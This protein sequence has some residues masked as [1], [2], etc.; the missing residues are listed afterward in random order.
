MSHR[1]TVGILA[2]CAAIATLWVAGSASADE[3]PFHPPIPILDSDGGKVAATGEPASPAQTC[4]ACHDTAFITAHA[5]HAHV[6]DLA[7]GTPGLQ[8]WDLGPGWFGAWDPI[9]GD[10][11]LA[12]ADDPV[13]IA[14]WMTTLGTRHAGGGPATGT[15]FD[16]LICHLEGVDLEARNAMIEAGRF[17][18][19]STAALAST[20]AVGYSAGVWSWIPEAFEPD[21]S[22]RG[23]EPQSPSATACSACH[24]V[25]VTEPEVV[26]VRALDDLNDRMTLLT[27][28]LI[29]GDRMVESGVNL[30]GK[31]D[32]SRPWDVHAERVVE[33][34]N[35]HH[36]VNNPA[37]FREGDATRPDH[38]L[39]DGRR[40]DPGLYLERPDHRLVNETCVTCHDATAAHEWLPYQDRHFEALACETC[41]IP[42][43]YAPALAVVDHTVVGTDGEPRREWRGV[44]GD[45]ASTATL[46]T[47]YEPVILASDDGT[48]APHNL[49]TTWFWVADGRPVTNQE[50]AEALL[51]DGK[52][53]PGIVAAFDTDGDGTVSEPELV[54]TDPAREQAV[55]DQLTAIGLADAV[56]SSEVRAYEIHHAVATGDWATS[57]CSTCHGSGSILDEVFPLADVIPGGVTP[58]PVGTAATAGLVLSADG[59]TLAFDPSTGSDDLYLFGTDRV[60]WIDIIG[61]LAILAVLAGVAVHGGFRW[62]IAKNRPTP[63]PEVESVYMYS[64]YERL[65]HWLQTIAILTLLGTGLVIHAPDVLGFLSFEWMVAIH[66]L[67]AAVLLIN[68][69]LAVFYH[70]ASGEVRQFIPRPQGFFDRAI[71]QAIYYVKGIFKGQ[72]HPFEKDARHKLNPLQQVTYFGILNVLLPLQI[73]TGII[74]WGVQRWPDL[75]TGIGGLTIVAPVHSLGAWFFAAFVIMHVYLTTTGH[76]PM[77][78][79]R[80]MITGWDEVEKHQIE[81]GITS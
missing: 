22:I 17:E 35:C 74:I 59:D 15:E 64:V 5:G 73:V 6:G 53:R 80:A 25:T 42:H 65:W 12:D 4:G 2:A 34:T 27:G 33:C 67:V 76:T 28:E 57:E 58:Q 66:N 52:Y 69:V 38:L 31:A 75:A 61:V 54:I 81:E 10:G 26:T 55:R 16:C 36:A 51:D 49:I 3:T 7:L 46:I 39:L 19:A 21:G 62:W 11:T 24:G 72:P 37:L 32:L 47:G 18:E 44:N 8:E 71:T 40:I 50:M 56:I 43:L 1:T 9:T 48:L 79:I 68:A 45:P 29:A 70:V 30:S 20:G 78:G 14:N 63:T 60:L 23:L 77:A 13:S 41:H